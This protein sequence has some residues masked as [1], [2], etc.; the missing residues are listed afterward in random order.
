MEVHVRFWCW[1]A[2]VSTLM[3]SASPSQAQEPAPYADTLA[4]S[5]LLPRVLPTMY[6]AMPS[7]GRVLPKG[8]AGRWNYGHDDEQGGG[9]NSEG[10]RLNERPQP[11]APV[12]ARCGGG[13]HPA[14]RKGHC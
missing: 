7:D 2:A 5:P 11:D 14:T 6:Q 1:L 3:L 13:E 4:W 8:G 10:G 12:V 9:E